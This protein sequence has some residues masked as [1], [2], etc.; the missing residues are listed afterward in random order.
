LSVSVSQPA[1]NV[2]AVGAFI[3]VETEA[4][5]QTREITIGG[6]TPAV[7]WAGII[8]DWAM[9]NRRMFA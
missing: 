6:G 1:P 2:D 4:G 5:V 9:Q 3:E 8:L 7:V